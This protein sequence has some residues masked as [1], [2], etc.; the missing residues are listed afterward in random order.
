MAREEVKTVWQTD[1]GGS[2]SS[3]QALNK[4]YASIYS[5]M[6]IM[7]TVKQNE[8]PYFFDS[9]LLKLTVTSN[10]YVSACYVTQNKCHS[11][12][13]PAKCCVFL[14]EVNVQT[15]VHDLSLHPSSVKFCIMHETDHTVSRLWQHFQWNLTILILSFTEKHFFF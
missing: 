5:F 10:M 13:A 14:R 11:V 7:S 15:S 8:V 9:M 1:R 2:V 12:K 6:L 4:G 3:V